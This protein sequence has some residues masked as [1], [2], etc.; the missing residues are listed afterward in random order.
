MSSVLLMSEMRHAQTRMSIITIAKED[1][2]SLKTWMYLNEAKVLGGKLNDDWSCFSMVCMI[3][4]LYNFRCWLFL[5]C[6]VKILSCSL[7]KSGRHWKNISVSNKSVVHK[8]RIYW[9]FICLYRCCSIS[10]VTLVEYNYC[11]LYHHV[12]YELM[13]CENNMICNNKK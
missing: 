8:P 4:M 5:A 11:L 9:T 6:F 7:Y 13:I 2:R 12:Y 10:I 3:V 1:M